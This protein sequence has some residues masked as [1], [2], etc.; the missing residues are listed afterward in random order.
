MPNKGVRAD[1]DRHASWSCGCGAPDR[2][3]GQ[4]ARRTGTP[5]LFVPDPRP[6][7]GIPT[8]GVPF[9]EPESSPAQRFSGSMA[10]SSAMAPP[11]ER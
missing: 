3:C 1:A 7:E 11:P 5:L 4:V 2:R 9:R 10:R 8:E 6:E